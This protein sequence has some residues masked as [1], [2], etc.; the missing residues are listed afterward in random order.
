MPEFVPHISQ[1]SGGFVRQTVG[2]SSNWLYSFERLAVQ[3]CVL[4]L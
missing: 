3:N 1:C 4:G 2:W